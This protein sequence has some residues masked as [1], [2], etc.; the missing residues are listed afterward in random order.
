MKGEL[1]AVGGRIP[2]FLKD[3]LAAFCQE[4]GQFESQ[5]ICKDVLSR[6]FRVLNPDPHPFDQDLDG[7]GCEV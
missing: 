6:N 1:P 5:V 2:H 7:I 4:T 3:K